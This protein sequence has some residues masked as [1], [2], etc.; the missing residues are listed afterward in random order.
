[1]GELKKNSF[2]NATLKMRISEGSHSKTG[3]TRGKNTT[4]TPKKDGD[5]SGKAAG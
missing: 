1:L 4:K 3:F 5:L 2:A